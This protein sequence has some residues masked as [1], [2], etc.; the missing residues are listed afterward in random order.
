MVIIFFLIIFQ[1]K[2][3]FEYTDCFGVKWLAPYPFYPWSFRIKKVH[4]SIE[5]NN[6]EN[7]NELTEFYKWK[8]KDRFNQKRYD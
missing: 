2:K 5:D 7:K 1:I 4:Y 8:V 6:H 3:I